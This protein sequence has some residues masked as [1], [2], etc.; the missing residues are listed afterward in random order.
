MH[1]DTNTTITFAPSVAD[2]FQNSGLGSKMFSAILEDLKE[3]SFKN[4]VLWGGVQATNTR[5]IHFYEKN[6]FTRIANFW[7][8]NKDNIDMVLSI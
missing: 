6:G 4:I 7:Y 5:A 2:A 3:L 1:F 8:D